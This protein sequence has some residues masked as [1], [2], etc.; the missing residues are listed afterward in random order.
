MTEDDIA[1]TLGLFNI[2]LGRP[3]P[4]LPIAGS[5]ERCLERAAAESVDG[6]IWIVERSAPR[7]AARKQAIA[8]SAAFL[9]ARL[10]EVKPWLAI[11]P[12]RYV[13][14][15]GSGVWQVSAYVPGIPLDRPAYA[16]EGWRGDALADLLIRFRLA[17]AGMPPAPGGEAPL[18]LPDF[19]RD[20]FGKLSS[21]EPALFERLYP[22]LLHLERNLFPALGGV[23]TRFC[24]GDF[25]P[26]NVIWSPSGI[27]ALIDFEFCGVRPEIYDPAMLVGC[28]GME[29]PRSLKGDLVGTL[30]ARLKSGAGYSEAGW[31]CFPDLVLGL[32]FAWLSDWLR[33]G[34][35]EMVELEAVF[36]G[37]LLEGRSALA[38]AGS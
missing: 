32:R 6:R 33:R 34:D 10:A 20:L 1:A 35:R 11:A 7:I 12:D 9:A 28:L 31:A 8:E 5:P 13:V 2:T 18:S 15:R 21:R 16:F 23:P 36:I 30:L 27:N 25:H 29:D 17:A 19:I 38:R 3:R 26:L 24:H 37:L 14:E 22:A 4:D